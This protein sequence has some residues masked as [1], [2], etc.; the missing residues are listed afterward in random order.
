MLSAAK[1]AAQRR[2]RAAVAADGTPAAVADATTAWM[3]EVDR[4]NRGARLA[5]ATLGRARHDAVKWQKRLDH[6]TQV[7]DGRRIAAESAAARCLDARRHLASCEEQAAIAEGVAGQRSKPGA[8]GE[9]AGAA[10][11]MRG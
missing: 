11:S 3:H 5:A 6:A 1:A 4:L 8:L 7:A 9:D 10:R 2:Y